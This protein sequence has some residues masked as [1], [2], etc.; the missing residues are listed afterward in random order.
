MSSIYSRGRSEVVQ[1][2]RQLRSDFTGRV[3]RNAAVA[4]RRAVTKQQIYS[5]FKEPLSMKSFKL[6]R[7]IP[8]AALTAAI[9]ATGSVGV[10]ALSNWFGANV[11]VKQ[12]DSVFSVDLSSCQGNLPPG[13]DPETTDRH[14]VQFKIL[15]SPHISADAL[16]QDLLAICEHNVVVD[17]YGEKFPDA[18]LSST[19]NPARFDDAFKYQL[20]SAQVTVMSD[21]G[22]TVKATAKKGASFDERSFT[23]A[24]GASFY[25]KG[26]LAT[27]NALKAGDNVTFLA[28]SASATP[29]MEG[30]SMLDNSD[31]QVLSAFKTQYSGGGA[32]LDYL[33]SNVMAMDAYNQLPNGQLYSE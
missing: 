10:Y 23:F 5:F 8:G 25:D 32:S 20:V 18:G 2:R 15:G 28:H 26:Q 7:T 31:V 30:V 16:Q 21:T 11:L 27:R 3:L 33:T 12:N 19:G 29:F 13:V 17:F 4:K 1:P 22:M 9:I 14:N 24:S 6:L